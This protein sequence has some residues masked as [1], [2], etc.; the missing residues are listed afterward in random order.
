MRQYKHLSLEEREKM[1]AWLEAGVTLREVG[2]RLGRDHGG[3]SKE[4]S[5]N[6]KGGRTYVPCYAQRRAKRVG[7]RQRY[8]APLKGPET[9]VYVRQHLRGPF[10]WTPETISGRIGIDIK[11][12]AIDTETIY[13]YIY[14]PKNNKDRLWQYLPCGRKRRMKKHGRKVQNKGKVPNAKSIDVRPKLVGTRKVP[15]HWETDNVCGIRLSKPALSVI[16]ERSFR[17]TLISKVL[18]QTMLEKTRSVVKRLE[19]KPKAFLKSITADNGRENYGHQDTSR[20]LG[21]EMYFCHAY[22]SW[23]KGTVE[24]RNKQIRRFFPK[25]TDFTHVRVGH[26]QAVEKII[27]NTPLKCLGYLTP[28]EKMSKYLSSIKST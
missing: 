3:L 19:G 1:Y 21:I 24:N 2:R 12:A 15:G 7:E 6:R 16:V 23:E 20:A 14:S 25:G 18:N 8:K 22:H 5:R 10:F 11:G 28:Y 26:I 13:R 9:L 27:N 17:V 4:L